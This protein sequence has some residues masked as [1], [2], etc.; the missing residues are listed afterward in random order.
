MTDKVSFNQL[1][2]CILA[3]KITGTSAVNY[4]E[5]KVNFGEKFHTWLTVTLP[6]KGYSNGLTHDIAGNARPT[7]DEASY[8]PGCRQGN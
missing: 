1:R 3:A 2:N 5:D 6:G 8:W 4:D 7:G